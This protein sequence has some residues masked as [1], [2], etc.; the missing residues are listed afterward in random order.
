MSEFADK[1]RRV[2]EICCSILLLSCY[3]LSVTSCSSVLRLRPPF[4]CLEA[5]PTAN[6]ASV[7]HICFHLR[8]SDTLRQPLVN[9]TRAE[10]SHSIDKAKPLT[11]TVSR[12][13][14]NARRTLH[15]SKSDLQQ[16]KVPIPPHRRPRNCRSR[17]ARRGPSHKAPHSRRGRL[18]LPGFREVHRHDRT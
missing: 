13:P 4:R 9:C 17:C 5:S 2:E 18:H 3:G 8:T 6:P 11:T 15:N 1:G 10:E 12:P 14:D 16:Q 7:P